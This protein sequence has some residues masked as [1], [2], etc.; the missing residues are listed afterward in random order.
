MLSLVITPHRPVSPAL[1]TEQQAYL[2][3]EALPLE[4]DLPTVRQPVNL[5][6]AL[7]RSGSMDGEKLEAVRQAALHIVERLGPQDNLA[8]VVFD[9]AEPAEWAVAP[10]AVIDKEDL[11]RRI[12]DIQ[13]RGGTHMSTGMRLALQ[14]LQQSGAPNQVKQLFL[15]TD[16]QT[17]E[18]SEDCLA[19][20]SICQQAGIS[21]Q[22]FGLGL[23]SENNWDPQFLEELA[24]RSGGEWN[25]IETPAQLDEIFGHA[26]NTLQETAAVNARLVL[27]LVNGVSP[28]NVWRVTPLISRLDAQAISQ[29]DVQIYLGDIHYGNGQAVLAELI[30]PPRPAGSYRLA[31]AELIYDNPQSQQSELRAAADCIFRFSDAPHESAVLNEAMMN[32]IE[33]VTAHRLQTQALD[34]AAAGD[35]AHATRKLRAAAT[36][37]LELGQTEMAQEAEWQAQRLEQDGRLDLADAQKMRY[38]TKRLTEL[39]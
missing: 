28:R 9:D 35:M 6:L 21:L 4:N 8:V 38:A 13:A 29:H 33:R 26:L 30:L 25:L 34:A 18:D 5:C 37:L 16:G 11:R 12:R 7:D 17:W 14:A 10:T 22:V 3:I 27:R 23:G 36:R 32:L 20:A 24:R 15:L 2:L 39:D 31:H 19:L 1:P